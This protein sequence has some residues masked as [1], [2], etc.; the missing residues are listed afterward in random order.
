MTTRRPEPG[1][2]WARHCADAWPRCWLDESRTLPEGFTRPATP[3]ESDLITG[4]IGE[5][6]FLRRTGKPGAPSSPSS[7]PAGKTRRGKGELSLVVRKLFG[8]NRF[9][10]GLKDREPKLTPLA[11]ALWCWLWR[12]A[13]DGHARATENRLGLRFGVCRNTI[14]KKLRELEQAG[15]L[16]TIRKGKK[17]R[18]PTVYRV[19]PMP[20]T[21]SKSEHDRV[22]K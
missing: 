1:S 5:A 10:D 16:S 3:D 11:V 17:L 9:L 15:F 22:K 6:E 14:R 13:K 18:S 21:G 8:W 2:A 19:R 7:K 20:R 4:R 12:C